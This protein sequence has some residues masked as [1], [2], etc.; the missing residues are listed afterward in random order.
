MVC[1]ASCKEE[2]LLILSTT[3]QILA[4]PSFNKWA[5]SPLGRHFCVVH[6]RSSDGV[7][8]SRSRVRPRFMALR[9]GVKSDLASVVRLASRGCNLYVTTFDGSIDSLLYSHTLRYKLI[10]STTVERDEQN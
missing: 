10:G 1:T 9:D 8:L 3:Q 4:V 7:L 2:D 6:K 5:C